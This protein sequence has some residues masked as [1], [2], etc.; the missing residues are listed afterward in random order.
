MRG[1]RIF[2]AIPIPPDV[3]KALGEATGEWR[4]LPIR[5]TAPEHIHVTL[6]F[7]GSVGDDELARIVSVLPLATENFSSFDVCLTRISIGPSLKTPRM[8]WAEG[9]STPELAALQKRARDLIFEDSP[10]GF[11]EDAKPFRLHVT[12]GRMIPLRWKRV[13]KEARIEKSISAPFSVHAINLMESGL[14]FDGPR[15]TVLSSAELG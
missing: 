8:V 2:V 15:Y 12:L 1:H 10:R 14:G 13:A 5:W 6:L 3:Q 9:D 4:E 7:I 11:V